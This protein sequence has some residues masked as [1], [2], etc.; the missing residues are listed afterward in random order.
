MLPAVYLGTCPSLH[1]SVFS[2][3]IISTTHN[4]GLGLHRKQ[5]KLP[6][7]FIQNCIMLGLLSLGFTL[8][9][10]FYRWGGWGQRG[11]T[12]IIHSHFILCW[13]ELL[14]HLL[15]APLSCV[16]QRRFKSFSINLE[17]KVGVLSQLFHS[18]LSASSI[19]S[20]VP[21]CFLPLGWYPLHIWNCW[22]FS[23]QFWFQ[24]VSHHAWLFAWC[25]LHIS[26]I[27]R[28]TIYNLVVLL[29][30]FWTNQLFHIQF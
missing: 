27:I 2:K 30:Q 16:C 23:W 13:A 8:L 20:L 15:L 28:M 25:T 4:W 21:L 19:C 11:S 7:A 14:A 24:F 9:S 12:V 6:V 17:S 22:Y 3:I 10:P 1:L 29:S 18:S 5:E 26:Q